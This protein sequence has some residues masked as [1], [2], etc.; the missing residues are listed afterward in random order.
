MGVI[1]DESNTFQEYAVLLAESAGRGL[2]AVI[3]RFKQ[4][5]GCEN[6]TFHKLYNS[7]VVSFFCY[8]AGIWGYNRGGA[9]QIRCKQ[10]LRYFMGVNKFTA[11]L[12]LQGDS[13]WLS[14]EYIFD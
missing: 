9:A 4:L 6:K 1:F 13:S 11:Y 10:S 8:A 3:S 7:S 14:P 5:K 12:F 2:C